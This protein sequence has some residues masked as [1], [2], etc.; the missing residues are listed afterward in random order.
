MFRALGTDELAFV[1]RHMRSLV[2]FQEIASRKPLAALV[3]L[4]I[5]F[6]IRHM[7]HQPMGTQ[8]AGISKHFATIIAPEEQIH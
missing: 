2:Q 6:L 7:V 3:A 8:H 5:A 4:K 1:G